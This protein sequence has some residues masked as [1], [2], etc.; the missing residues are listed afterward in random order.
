M[1]KDSPYGVYLNVQNSLNFHTFAQ[2][3]PGVEDKQSLLNDITYFSNFQVCQVLELTDSS[4][5]P[6]PTILDSIPNQLCYTGIISYNLA[7][8]Y[9]AKLE[10]DKRGVHSVPNVMRMNYRGYL[11]DYLIS[12]KVESTVSVHRQMRTSSGDLGVI[13]Y[14]RSNSIPFGMISFNVVAMLLHYGVP[15]ETLLL[16]V[17]TYVIEKELGV[18]SLRDQVSY[19]YSII[20]KND[21]YA[22]AIQEH[23]NLTYLIRH[24]H[25]PLRPS[26]RLVGVIDPFA[27]LQAGEVALGLE[28][29]A[30]ALFGK[31]VLVASNTTVTPLALQRFQVK[32]EKL[33]GVDFT[34]CVVFNA[35]DGFYYMNTEF[36]SVNF[37]YRKSDFIVISEKD[38]DTHNKLMELDI[39]PV[40]QSM[41]G[42]ESF[43]ALVSKIVNQTDAL[44]EKAVNY[45]LLRAL[46][47]KSR[48]DLDDFS[49]VL[50]NLIHTDERI[51]V[52]EELFRVPKVPHAPNF[53][54]IQLEPMTP[55]FRFEEL[56]NGFVED[57]ARKIE[58][59]YKKDIRE[60][61]ALKVLMSQ[62]EMCSDEDLENARKQWFHYSVQLKKILDGEQNWLLQFVCGAALK[63]GGIERSIE[64]LRRR[65]RMYNGA[66]DVRKKVALARYRVVYTEKISQEK[67][68]LSPSFAFLMAETLFL[69]EQDTFAFSSRG[70]LLKQ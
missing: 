28:R 66:P 42:D 20:D 31:T 55:Y 60:K 59:F 30:F 29:S 25:I 26:Y 43:G 44:R 33:A 36:D 67:A 10:R 57:E 3:F 6:D 32:N 34:G 14:D 18:V 41:K 64:S 2:D 1:G 12:R 8:L 68:Y 49:Y 48:G 22:K 46:V 70:G 9:W 63:K 51:K 54:G 69:K 40:V 58:A 35:V 65:Y 13:M 61:S 7:E 37:N 4:Q 47:T 24:R 23:I 45:Q 56:F 53:F 38:K 52:K 27:V 5:L 19:L 62:A 15:P 21:P 39:T 11:G 16:P 50:F 17:P